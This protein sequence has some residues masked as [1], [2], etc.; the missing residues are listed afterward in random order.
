MKRLVILFALFQSCVALGVQADEF[1][2]P[3]T[4]AGRMAGN[5]LKAINSG[6]YEALLAFQRESNSQAD[7]ERRALMGYGLYLSTRGIEPHRVMNATET[8]VEF[9]AR[10]RLSEQWLRVT[11]RVADQEPHGVIGISLRPTE[12]PTLFAVGSKADEAEMLTET[13]AF[14]A[15]M[16]EADEFSGAVLIARDGKPVFARAYGLASRAYQAPIRIDTKFCL[17]SMGKM[18]TATAIVQLA[19]QKKLAFED[20]VG[21]HLPE[22]PNAEVRDRVTIH[23]LLTHTS[24]LGDIFGEKYEQR[25]HKLRTVQDWIDLFAEDKL[26]FEPGSRFGYSNAGFCLLGLIIEKVS[27]EEYW[28]YLQKNVFDR[29][30]M[31]NTGAFELDHDPP[32]LAIGY[33]RARAKTPEEV[34]ARLN[35]LFLHGVKGSPAGGAYS[36]VEDM[37]AFANALQ[38][39]RLLSAEMTETLFE[40]HVRGEG[41]GYGFASE[42]AGRSRWIGHGGGFPGIS[43][44]LKMYPEAGYTTVVLCNFDQVARRVGDRFGAWIAR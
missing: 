10:E 9:L 35:N 5:W 18:F 44:E 42:G 15:R 34:R 3:D 36:T 17:A 12:A 2:L 27:G 8:Q 26:R 25:M 41:Y 33:T 20:T 4:P 6:E 21:K 11:L 13:E 19:E 24:G 7:P 43:T 40:P 37:L 29:A 32:N 16:A 23:Q 39:H 31:K 14:L 22:Y 1:A 38:E 28:A 30:G